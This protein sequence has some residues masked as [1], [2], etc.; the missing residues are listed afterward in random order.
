MVAIV[1]NRG[2]E[3]AHWVVV[4]TTAANWYPTKL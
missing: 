2:V 1:S 3:I 4:N